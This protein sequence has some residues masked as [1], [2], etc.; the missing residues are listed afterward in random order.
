MCIIKD[1]IDWSGWIVLIKKWNSHYD[2]NGRAGQFWHMESVLRNE[3]TPF[4][5]QAARPSRGS[6]DQVKW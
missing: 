5:L 1:L 4:A 2:G 6:N 3:G